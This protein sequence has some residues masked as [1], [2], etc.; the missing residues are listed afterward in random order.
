M[1]GEKELRVKIFK[2]NNISEYLNKIKD[3]RLSDVGVL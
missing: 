2:K 1:R 3:N